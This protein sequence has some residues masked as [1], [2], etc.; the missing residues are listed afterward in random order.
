MCPPLVNYGS[1]KE[2][3]DHYERVYCKGGII[4]NDGIS[5]FFGKDDFNHIFFE[6]IRTKDDTF[7]EDR[8]KRIDW[9]KETITNSNSILYQGYD[10]QTKEYYPD[11]R[12]ALAYEDFVVVVLLSL[13]K[14]DQLKGKIITCYYADNSIDKIKA[15]ALWDKE[16][17]LK[18][19][20][21]QKS[22]KDQK[23]DQRKDKK[24]RRNKKY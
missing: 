16:E 21:L 8:S 18:L 13:N 14:N 24:P 2:Y 10:R 5:I 20:E 6:S 22:V 23:K 12:V 11:R 9:I 1:E 3:R 17:C 15:S 7:S 4:T 19:L